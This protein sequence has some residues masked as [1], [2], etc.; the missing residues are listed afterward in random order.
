MGAH[1]HSKMTWPDL[2]P[3]GFCGLRPGYVPLHPVYMALCGSTYLCTQPYV[4]Q[5]GPYV[6]QHGPQVAQLGPHAIQLEPPVL[7]L[8]PYAPQLR[9]CVLQLKPTK[10]S[11]DRSLSN[12]TTSTTMALSSSACRLVRRR[13][14]GQ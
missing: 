7:Q 1:L 4:A 14:A 6:P 11:C 12:P 13:T 3:A 9:P 5:H 2:I 10:P 8:G